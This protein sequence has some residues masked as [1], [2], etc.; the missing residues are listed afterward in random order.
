MLFAMNS[1]VMSLIICIIFSEKITRK[2]IINSIRLLIIICIVFLNNGAEAVT[3]RIMR[4]YGNIPLAF[5]VNEG[6]V[7]SQ[8]K[9]T[10]HGSGVTCFLPQTG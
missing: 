6:Q 2:N 5:T 10:A 8:V 4:N 7:D 1:Y 9:F 3:T